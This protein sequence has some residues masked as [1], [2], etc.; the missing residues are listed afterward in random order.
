M[1][2]ATVWPNGATFEEMIHPADQETQFEAV[3]MVGRNLI[4]QVL[5]PIGYLRISVG[6]CRH[7]LADRAAQFLS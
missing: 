7:N 5:R 6:S 3:R 4:E 1:S 2:K